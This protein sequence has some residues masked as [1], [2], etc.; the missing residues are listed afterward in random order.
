[1]LF[2]PCL[3]SGPAEACYPSSLCQKPTAP[4]ETSATGRLA[5]ILFRARLM[6]LLEYFKGKTSAC[7][8]C[9]Q[10]LLFFKCYLEKLVFWAWEGKRGLLWE[11]ASFPHIPKWTEASSERPGKWQGERGSWESGA[12][13][14]VGK[15]QFTLPDPILK[16]SNCPWK[17]KMGTM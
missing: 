4:L 7:A 13:C 3:L 6:N 5:I 12:N 11:G 8:T 14:K 15:V 1:M 16:N 10:D 2:S 9:F 17:S